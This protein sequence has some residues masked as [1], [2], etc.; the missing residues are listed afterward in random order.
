MTGTRPGGRWPRWRGAAGCRRIA[1]MTALPSGR[2]RKS[3][4]C[5]RRSRRCRSAIRAVRM[6]ERLARRAAGSS[7]PSTSP[8]VA[9]WLQPDATH[10]T[11]TTPHLSKSPLSGS[12]CDRMIRGFAPRAAPAPRCL[13]GGDI[14]GQKKRQG[15]LLSPGRPGASAVPGAVSRAA[16]EPG[17]DARRRRLRA[18]AYLRKALWR[19]LCDFAS[20][21]EP[22]PVRAVTRHASAVRHLRGPDRQ[23]AAPGSRWLRKRRAALR[24]NFR[25]NAFRRAGASLCSGPMRRISAS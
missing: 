15:P 21:P 4:G 17:Q 6:T 11:A 2:W 25:I 12:G 18:R 10:A 5:G 13:S 22:G 16:P 9:A 19:P 1:P 3:G 20:A 23:A 24:A 7:V 8:N 14:S